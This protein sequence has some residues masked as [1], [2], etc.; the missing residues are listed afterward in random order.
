MTKDPKS[1]PI[2]TQQGKQI[3]HFFLI[4]YK[5]LFFSAVKWNIFES[6]FYQLIFIFIFVTFTRWNNNK[7]LTVYRS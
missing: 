3:E 4:F 5:K 6:F 1:L 2:S 7:A